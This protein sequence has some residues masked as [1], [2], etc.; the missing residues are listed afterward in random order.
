MDISHHWYSLT[1]ILLYVLK[2][3]LRTNRTD[4]FNEVGHYAEH[5]V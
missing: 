2:Y 3:L 4:I 1:Q 5:Y